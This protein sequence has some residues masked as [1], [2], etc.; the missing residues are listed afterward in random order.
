MKLTA[1][2]PGFKAGILAVA[3]AGEWTRDPAA[4]WAIAECESSGLN[5]VT[6][7]A[8]RVM[9]STDPVLVGQLLNRRDRLP[10]GCFLIFPYFTPTGTSAEYARVK[11]EHPRTE[12][13]E[14]EPREV[15]YDAP[16]GCPSRLYIPPQVIPILAD[17]AVELIVGEGEKKCLALNQH[18]F[19]AVA[20]A[21]VWNLLKKPDDVERGRSFDDYEFRWPKEIPVKGRRVVLLFDSDARDKGNLPLAV[22]Y[23]RQHLAAL[24]ANVRVVELPD[25]ADG[26]KVG[27]DDYLVAHGPAALRAIVDATPVPAD[28]KKS[29]KGRGD[30]GDGDGGKGPAAAE[31]LTTIGSA[32]DLWHD[33]EDKAFASNGRRSVAVRS[34]AFRMRLVADYRRQTGGKVPNAEALSAALLSIEAAAVLDGPLCE[35]NVRVAEHAGQVYVH[36]VDDADTVIAIDA[37]GWRECPDPPVRFV[38]ARGMQAL[39]TPRAG[40]SLD[41]L[42]RVLNCPDD[43]TFAL[44]RAWFAQVFRRPGPFPV[45]VLLGEQGS[46]KTT[47]SRVLKRLTDPRE[48][49]V[50][51]EPK[52]AR[53][54]MIGA[55]HNW[56]LAFDNLSGLPGWLSDALCR[57]A[58]GGSFAIRGVYTDDEEVTFTAKRPVILN[59]IEDFVTRPDLLERSL[60]IHHPPIPDDRRRPEADV[61]AEFADLAPRLLGAVFDYVAGGLREMPRL[62]KIA[63]PRMADF[64][65]FATACE[66][67]RAGTGDGFLAP[68]RD[69]R[70]G[71]NEQVLDGSP[72][73][74]ALQKLMADRAE[75][76]GTGTELL[77][78]LKPL[79]PD[80]ND[81]DWPKKPNA[82]SGKLKRLAP[83]LRA[84]AGLD[85]QTGGKGSDRKRTRQI[86]IR[87]LPD[88]SRAGSSAPSAPPDG[89]ASQPEPPTPAADDP[90]PSDEPRIVRPSSDDVAGNSPGMPPADGPDGADDLS[91][92]SGRRPPD[93]PVEESGKRKQVRV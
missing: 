17:P 74:A 27:A 52:E 67:A 50:R 55:N 10:R 4:G 87:K 15:K 85:V 57:L 63:L 9:Y 62:G 24:G 48:A 33:A 47:T 91:R 19:P 45:L 69:N 92:D 46:A 56:V 31:F 84:A 6:A 73:A 71:A 7:E 3:A 35:A 51:A 81:R 79:T 37:D 82:L 68:Y 58:T 29:K 14:G 53:D 13:R 22:K 23:I 34:R 20:V 83:S 72:V 70:A 8:N 39:P 60:V 93:A 40:G 61:W 30:D 21:G 66:V 76:S 5:P 90:R 43:G 12:T 88:V 86:T 75:W 41:D 32:Y 38:R 26:K 18:G 80:P 65:E 54:L 2:T 89:P 59:G 64:A 36:L 77:A 25:A 42:R 28:R 16:A 1:D 44:I 11:P 49:E 78:L